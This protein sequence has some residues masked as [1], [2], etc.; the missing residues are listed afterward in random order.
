MAISPPGLVVPGPKIVTTPRY[1]LLSTIEPV[2]LDE[3][4]AWAGG[5][6]WEFDLCTS[7]E[8]FTDQCP[9]ATGYTMMTEGDLEFCHADPFVVKSSF[10]CATVGLSVE[11]AVNI[12]KRRLQAWESYQVEKVLWTGVT[13]T[14]VIN[15]SFAFG[16]DTCEIEPVN[17]TTIGALDVV[18]GIGA[19]EEALTDVV[20]GGGIIHV[21]YGLASYLADKGLLERQGDLYFSATGFPIIIG[22][23]YPG[24]GPANVPA[25]PGTTWIFGTGPVGIW[26]SESFMVPED[27]FE[28]F[29][30]FRNDLVVFSERFYAVGF[31]CVVYAALVCL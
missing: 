10:K 2:E 31:S 22:A 26:R 30:R 4:H 23:G 5:V 20:P 25:D 18:A 9:P 1:G 15:P 28:G 12:A 29:D 13:S 14:G 27:G 7:V 16:N 17:I 21:P 24:S 3:P 11:K 6:E 19:L 8:A